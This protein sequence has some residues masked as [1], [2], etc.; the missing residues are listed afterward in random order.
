M[1]C[2]AQRLIQPRDL[3]WGL[4][5]LA[6]YFI[7][8]IDVLEIVTA[9]KCS[10]NFQCSWL[11]YAPNAQFLFSLAS[12]LANYPT[13]PPDTPVT[14]SQPTPGTS[15]PAPVTTRPP[16][17]LTTTTNSEGG[18][19]LC[20]LESCD[21]LPNITVRP[22]NVTEY[23]AG[24]IN[25]E[26]ETSSYTDN[27]TWY[28]DSEMLRFYAGWRYIEKSRL[29][30]LLRSPQQDNGWYTC[31][32]SN[33]YGSS[34]ASAY[35]NFRGCYFKFLLSMSQFNYVKSVVFKCCVIIHVVSLC[36]LQLSHVPSRNQVSKNIYFPVPIHPNAT[37]NKVFHI[38][39]FR[40]IPTLMQLHLVD[41]NACHRKGIN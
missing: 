10:E 41:Q 22:T 37:A 38:P 28:K 17:A 18:P 4:C 13:Q 25:F 19:S 21:L 1:A 36:Y 12:F 20:G 30:I 33:L 31:V 11:C 26:C 32:A 14:E 8:A 40:T 27:I 34:N 9:H 3:L 29:A 35:L 5:T 6:K 23:I 24:W 16:T 15:G 39:L 7:K 2:E